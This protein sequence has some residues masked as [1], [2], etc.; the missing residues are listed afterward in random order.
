MLPLHV[1]RSAKYTRIMVETKSGET[2]DGKL[3]DTDRF[4]NMH[5]ED[6]ILTSSTGDKFYKAKKVHLRGDKIKSL[7]MD[8][9]V[10]TNHLDYIEAK[11]NE[12]GPKRGSRGTRGERGQRGYRGYRGERGRGDRGR[13]DRGRGDRGRGYRGRGDRGRGDRGRGDRGRGDRG[14]GYRGS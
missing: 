9:K 13:G 2:Y 14:R 3:E 1:I 11:R 7:Q 4:M 8:P 12:A 5:L 10:L 6:V